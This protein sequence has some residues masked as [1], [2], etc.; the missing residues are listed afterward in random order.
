MFGTRAE[1][2]LS[3][4][5]LLR[6]SET[7]TVAITEDARDVDGN[8]LAAGSLVTFTTGDFRPL[9]HWVSFIA[10]SSS[11]PDGDGGLWI[12]NENR[13]PRQLVSA[14]VT[15]FSWS[16]DASRLLIRGPTGAWTDQALDGPATPLSIEGEWAAY[17]AGGR[18]YAFLDAGSLKLLQPDG[19]VAT[20]ATSVSTAAVT[21]GGDRLAFATADPTAPERGSQVEGYD[22]ILRT[23]FRLGAE[24][25]AVDGMAWSPDGQSLAYRVDQ[26]DPLKRQVRVRS[27]RDGGVVTVATGPLST[28][29]WQADR[30]SGRER[31]RRATRRCPRRRSPRGVSLCFTHRS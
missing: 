8:Y 1:P 10:E 13:F 22:P 2:A 24:P 19:M 29:A 21:P 26:G 14:P 20:V 23:R 15:A 4:Q 18:G 7:Y 27:L 12:V 3:P 11:A 31:R 9:R 6:P 17:L 28:P 16:P 25:A 5:S 30:P